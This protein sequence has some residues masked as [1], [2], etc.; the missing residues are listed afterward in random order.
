MQF[1]TASFPAELT[2]LKKILEFLRA[3]AKDA[4]FST[5][6]L[7]R[8]DLVIEEIAVNVIRYAYSGGGIGPL[9]IDCAV[10]REGE[11]LV[12]IADRGA[13]FDPLTKPDPDRQLVLQDRPVGGLGVF[14]VKQLVSAISYA[15]SD[16]WNRLSLQFRSEPGAK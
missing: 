7:D 2:S 10:L 12:R 4:R 15:R 16:G 11:L 1:T 6:D 8:L 3:C 14:L 13:P 5:N 9:Q